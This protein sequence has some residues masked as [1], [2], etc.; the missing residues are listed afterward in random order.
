MTIVNQVSKKELVSMVSEAMQ[1]LKGECGKGEFQSYSEKVIEKVFSFNLLR[2]QEELY[3]QEIVLPPI[4]LTFDPFL[5]GMA[6][7][8]VLEKEIKVSSLN[9]QKSLLVEICK[10]HSPEP[11]LEILNA[12]MLFSILHE[13]GHH[14]D[15]ESKLHKTIGDV[16]NE[17]LKIIGDNSIETLKHNTEAQKFILE[18]ANDLVD[19]EITADNFAFSTVAKYFVSDMEILNDINEKQR[20]ESTYPKY[21]NRRIR[22]IVTRLPQSFSRTDRKELVEHYEQLLQTK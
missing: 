7:Y 21:A 12:R 19:K 8:K 16:S 10:V 6:A 20:R 11:V 1:I 9:Y 18:E 13:L 5:K 15:Y 4:Y 22:D 17:F 2:I 14:F 3:K